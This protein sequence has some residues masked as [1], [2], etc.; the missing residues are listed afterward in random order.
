MGMMKRNVILSVVFGLVFVCAAV[1]WQQ[2]ERARKLEVQVASLTAD[3]HR[4]ESDTKEQ[5]ELAARLKSENNAYTNEASVLRNKLALGT[6]SAPGTADPQV[7]ASPGQKKGGMNEFLGSMMKDPKMK[8]MMR[9]Q[10]TAVLKQMYGDFV[11]AR[12][13]SPQQAD[14]FFNLLVEKQMGAMEE[15]MKAFDDGEKKAETT[16]SAGAQ[17]LADQKSETDRQLQM[18]LGDAGYSE[19]QAYE[20][21]TGERMALTQMRQ[22]LA[23]N[24]TPLADEQATTLLQVMVEENAKSP[25][26]P[27]ESGLGNPREKL[28]VLSDGNNAEQFYQRQAELNQRILDRAGSVLNPDQYSALESYQKQQLEMQKLGM[29]MARKMMNDKDE[30]HATLIMPGTGP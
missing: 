7:A 21:T 26:S 24:N 12:H 22:Q 9:Q 8:E 17:T 10:Q 28:R 4:R 6:G 30:S 13:F 27:L 5:R 18:L 29:E 3:L 1:A 25:P 14:Q 19:Y 2:R 15:G 23:L 20:K 11:K 16:D